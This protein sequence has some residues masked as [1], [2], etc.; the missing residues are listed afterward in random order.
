MN[1][2][3]E[4]SEDRTIMANERTFSSWT[5][6]GMGAIGLALAFALLFLGPLVAWGAVVATIAMWSVVKFG[7][8][9]LPEKS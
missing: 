6:G 4:L 9:M 2:S 3:T 7:T 5:G 8:F 1:T